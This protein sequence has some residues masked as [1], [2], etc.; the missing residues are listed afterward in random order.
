MDLRNLSGIQMALFQCG[1]ILF[2]LALFA[3]VLGRYFKGK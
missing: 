2:V 1:V 3:I